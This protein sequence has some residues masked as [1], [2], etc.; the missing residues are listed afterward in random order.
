MQYPA[1]LALR[2]N[3]QQIIIPRSNVNLDVN[4]SINIR[5]F[6]KSHSLQLIE[7]LSSTERF[8]KATLSKISLGFKS[9]QSTVPI[10]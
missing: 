9:A 1:P 5:T 7:S 10:L 4:L 3:K 8:F 6:N 2:S